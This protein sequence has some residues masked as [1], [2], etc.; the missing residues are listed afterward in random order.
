VRDVTGTTQSVIARL[1]SGRARPS[2]KTLE[3]LATA[4]GTLIRLKRPSG[5]NGDCLPISKNDPVADSDSHRSPKS[6]VERARLGWDTPLALMP[7]R[8]IIFACALVG[9][10]LF[11]DRRMDMHRSVLTVGTIS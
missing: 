4:T 3:R 7:G 1:E 8:S 11:L 2:T 6:G 10:L 9:N 5:E